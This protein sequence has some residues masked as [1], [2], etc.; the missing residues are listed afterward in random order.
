[1]ICARSN[2][3]ISSERHHKDGQPNGNEEHRPIHDV[4][5]KES[6]FVLIVKHVCSLA[7][8]SIAE[9]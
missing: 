6:G 4:E 8:G 5:A 7:F 2:N 3:S 9:A 1:M